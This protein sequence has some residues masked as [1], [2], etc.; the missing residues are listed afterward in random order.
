MQKIFVFVLFLCL[1]LSLYSYCFTGGD[2]VSFEGAY[3][4]ALGF[5]NDVG[6]VFT[7]LKDT[8]VSSVQ[9]I[10]SLP[11]KLSSFVTDFF[12]NIGAK[13]TA[14][15]NT[16]GEFFEGLVEKIRAFFAGIRNTILNIF[17]ADT[18]CECAD[19]EK[20]EGCPCNAK[21]CQC[22]IIG[23]SHGKR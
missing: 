2:L 1:I 6:S 8:L 22:G 7:G 21:D 23:G 4:K 14:L 3:S 15:G 11:Q 13:F 5:V 18:K 12:T 19:P 9:G 16:I 10:V 20:C 17:G